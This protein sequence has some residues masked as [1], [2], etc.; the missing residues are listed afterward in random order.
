MLLLLKKQTEYIGYVSLPDLEYNTMP[1][2]ISAK[3]CI[4]QRRTAIKKKRAVNPL[5]YFCRELLNLQ[6][7]QGYQAV[8]IFDLSCAI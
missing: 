6:P 4:G 3:A 8:F 5:I 2:G 1:A 7:L